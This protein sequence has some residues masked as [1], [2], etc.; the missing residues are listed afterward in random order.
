MPRTC[1]KKIPN[2]SRA[3]DNM[4]GFFRWLRRNLERY[5]DEECLPSP[6]YQNSFGNS[7]GNSFNLT[8]S[9]AVGGTVVQANFYTSYKDQDIPPGLYVIHDGEDLGDALSKIIMI[10]TLKK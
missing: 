8:V 2:V 3:E 9:K 6:H 1:G 7:F 5:N 10:E 4:K